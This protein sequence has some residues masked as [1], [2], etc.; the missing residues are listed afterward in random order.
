MPGKRAQYVQRLYVGQVNTGLN[1][2][3]ALKSVSVAGTVLEGEIGKGSDS[4]PSCD[5]RLRVRIK[6]VQWKALK[7][8]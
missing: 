6:S 3:Q 2:I 8:F 5:P 7:E 4:T 1:W